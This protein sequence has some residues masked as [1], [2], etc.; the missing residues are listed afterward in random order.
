MRCFKC[1]FLFW[2]EVKVTQI[3]RK[4]VSVNLILKLAL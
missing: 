1:F 2:N 3:K 4:K